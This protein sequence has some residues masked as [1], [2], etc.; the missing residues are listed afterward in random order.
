ME[1]FTT[2][3]DVLDAVREAAVEFVNYDVRPGVNSKGFFGNVPLI[4]AITWGN[5]QAVELLLDAGA[6][7]NVPCEGGNTP[8]HEAIQAAQFEIA[9]LLVAR[10]ANQASRNAEGKLPRDLC[11][12]GEWTGI[13]GERNDI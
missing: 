11:W 2:V 8:L 3:E 6:D 5:K 7:I 4:V 1:K 9:R 13:F 12:E 10:G